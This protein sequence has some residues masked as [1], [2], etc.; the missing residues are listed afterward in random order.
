MQP[1]KPKSPPPI[2]DVRAPAFIPPAGSI[3]CHVHIIGPQTVYPLAPSTPVEL[4]DS[5]L[6]D[7]EKVQNALGI[8]RALIVA[9]G[10][11]A[12]SYDHLVHLLCRNPENYRGVVIPAPEITN[13]ELRLL[14]DVGVV[15]ARFYPGINAPTRDA[16]D[17]V[18]AMGWT[19][20][21]PIANT[22]Q[23]DAWA[24]QIDSIEGKFV[25]EHSG[26][27]DPTQG[28]ESAHFKKILSYLDTG[29][30]WIKLSPRFSKL[31]L[32]PF[33]DTL[34]FIHALVARRPDRLLYGSDYPHPN[35][36][37]PMPNEADLLDLMLLWAPDEG[38]R[39]LIMRRNA[40]ELFGFS[41]AP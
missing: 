16:L 4:A 2:R 25:I 17:R 11:H 14:A 18:Q 15:G 12:F 19:A 8:P 35:Y 26:M 39:D 31:P 6:E 32:A 9:S 30:C 33:E 3:D 21:F 27:P 29:R 7:F 22:A 34:P 36:F 23:L 37:L 40:E 5:T 10:G 28:L 1:T 13:R 38:T 41:R 20:H 24:G